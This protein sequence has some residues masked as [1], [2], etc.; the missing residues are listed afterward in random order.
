MKRVLQIGR[1]VKARRVKVKEYRSLAGDTY[2][3]LAYYKKEK[4]K[5]GLKGLTPR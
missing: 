5:G 4:I 2:L 3:F 1:D